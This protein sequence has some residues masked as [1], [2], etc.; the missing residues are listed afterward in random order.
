MGVKVYHNGSWIELSNVGSATA[1]GNDKQIQFN[2]GGNLAGAANLEFQKSTTNPKIVLKPSDTSTS[3][4]GGAIFV[5]NANDSNHVQVSA[6]GGIEIRR[7][8]DTAAYGGPYL[9]FTYQDVDMDARIQMEHSTSP[10]GTGVSDP[11]FSSIK[12]ETGGGGSTNGGFGNVTEKF[13]ITKAGDLVLAHS[14][15]NTRGNTVLGGGVYTRSIRIAKTAA[16]T[17]TP[18]FQITSSAGAVCG[19]AYIT[20]SNDTN[21][22]SLVYNF[23]LHYLDGGDSGVIVLAADGSGY[24][25]TQVPANRNTMSMGVTTSTNVHTI[26]V[27]TAGPNFN[28]GTGVLVNVTLFLGASHVPITVTRP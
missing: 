20:C 19:T 5:E 14:H 27:N 4:N 28:V 16:S 23:A 7:S 25:P 22:Q 26:A 18:F 12:F 11:N 10:G 17:N 13:R 8:N 24:P 15:D 2:D 21:S 3:T 6:D 9:D 1:G